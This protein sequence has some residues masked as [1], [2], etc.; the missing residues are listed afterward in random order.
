MARSVYKFLSR[1]NMLVFIECVFSNKVI[2]FVQLK[3]QGDI[4]F[5]IQSNFNLLTEQQLF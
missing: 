1:C 4:R 2:R 3:E 5:P